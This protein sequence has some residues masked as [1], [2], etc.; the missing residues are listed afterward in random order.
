MKLGDIANSVG[1]GKTPKPPLLQVTLP[2]ANEFRGARRQLGSW[3]FDT[4][5]L[6]AQTP[7]L[8]ED[9]L[10]QFAVSVSIPYYQRRRPPFRVVVLAWA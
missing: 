2:F 5:P 3:K 8:I 4:P 1:H 10:S 9:R 7:R 6:R